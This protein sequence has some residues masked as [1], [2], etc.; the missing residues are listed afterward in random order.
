MKPRK[1]TTKSGETLWEYELFIG[2]DPITKKRIRKHVRGFP[3]KNEALISYSKLLEERDNN[4]N[5]IEQFK[6]K[7][8]TIRE[9]YG[10]WHA[11]YAPTVEASTISKVESYYKNHILPDMGDL[12]VAKVNSSKLQKQLNTWSV[13]AKSGVVWGRYLKKLFKY[14][15]LLNIITRNPFDAI[16][17]P[18][19]RSNTVVSHKDNFFSSEQLQRFLDYWSKKPIKQYAYFRLLA[20][21]GMRRG[22]IIALKWHDIDFN[23]KRLSIN[24]AVGLDYRGGHTKTYLKQTK[25]DS[26]YRTISLDKKTLDVLLEYRHS[27]GNPPETSEIWPGTHTWMDFN[28]PERWLQAMRKQADVD[29]DLKNITLHGLRHTHASIIFEQAAIHGNPVPIKA[30]QK[31]L[32]HSTVEMTLQIYTHMSDAESNLVDEMLTYGD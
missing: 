11:E 3:T 9:L 5:A 18:K 8:I 26:S 20:Y 27:L 2:R 29:D 23:K 4:A 17:M 15:V 28:V 1:Y 10:Y 31:R 24:K 19:E 22:E 30:V 32:G 12:K 21:S 25:T 13:E 16:T 14:A 6:L 7:E